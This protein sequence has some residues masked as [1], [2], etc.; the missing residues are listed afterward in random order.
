MSALKAKVKARPVDAA[1]ALLEIGSEELPATNLADLFENGAANPLEA[2]AR[3]VYEAHRIG[4]D[5][6]RVY[7][8]PR[9]LVFHATGV[10]PRQAAH[11][12]LTRL[13]TRQE[14]YDADGRPTEKLLTILKHRNGRAEDTLV[15]ESNGKEYVFLKK[16]EPVKPTA[17]V[18]PEV[19]AEI[20]KGLNFPKN[21]YWND[22]GF[23]FPRPIR[24]LLGLYGSRPVSFEAAGL[25]SRAE[26]VFFSKSRRQR[27]PVK[28]TAAYF[29]LLT[30]RGVVLDQVERKKRVKQLL[31]SLS[32]PL[33][34]RVYDDP[35][36]LNEV[37]YLVETPEGLAAPFGR[38]FLDLP[39]EVLTVSMARKQRLFGLV[40][41]SG[42]VMPS[43]LAVLD[44]KATESQKKIISRN[45]EGILRAK[46]QDSLFF[47]REDQ[48]LTL[49]KKRPELAGLVFLKNAGSMLEK[50]E[51]LERLAGRVGPAAG[52]D[53][54]EVR[55]LQRAARLCKSDLLTQ[56]VGEF[57]ELQGITGRYYAAAN[58]ESQG[59][60]LAIGEQY[61][62]RTVNDPL[63]S[64]RVGC[65]L[66]ALD[67]A[68]LI[69]A[70]FGLGLE[71]T[72]SLDPYGLRRSAVGVMKIAVEKGVELS[73]PE[74]VDGCLEEL[75]KYVPED[76]RK[77]ARG[78][79][80]GFY[81]DR[82]KAVL[83]DRGHREDVIDAALAA[84]FD[85]PAETARRVEVL[86]KLASGPD[87]IQASKVVER[88]SNILKGN[89]AE[90]PRQIRADLIREDLEREVYELY[91]RHAEDIRR[92][93]DGGDLA[94]AT[95]LYARTFF[96]ILEQFFEKVFVNHE[97]PAVRTNRLALLKGIRDLYTEKIA[98]LSKIRPS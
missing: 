25:R 77:A 13:L 32:R 49:E 51:R 91:S 98:D 56:M 35:F 66:S 43:F 60:A 74:L 96:A 93:V 16:A 21:M 86:S 54:Q 70:C 10:Q 68:D 4:I 30:Q 67:K 37:T 44:G 23:H 52:L 87:F 39:L 82:F 78:K 2:A 36:L 8:T 92:V 73:V 76:K 24:S 22:S 95:S 81:K 3:K 12:V 45:M 31:E 57:P 42:R 50:S 80:I 9:R 27:V 41:R 15:Q 48:K 7:A 14:S 26:T 75:S 90:L 20:V 55:D 19:F 69:A 33:G 29:K 17:Q 65:V 59:T 83:A 89:K 88:T 58:G 84:R 5:A 18:L 40:D 38:E 61:L 94:G 97:D 6:I 11:D 53:A 63:P 46:L 79:L 72:S 28:D 1:E 62:P 47:Y 85:S 71:P 34:A 64:T